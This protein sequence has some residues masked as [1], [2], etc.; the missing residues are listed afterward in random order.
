MSTVQLKP[1]CIN[2][3]SKNVIKHGVTIKGSPRF[4]C[5]DCEKT[6][7]ENNIKVFK[8]EVN[9]LTEEYLK[10]QTFRELVNLYKTAPI[11]IN[12]K[13]RAYLSQCPNWEEYIDKLTDE[14]QI[15]VI[16][17]T[18][19]SFA[20]SAAHTDDNS[21]YLALAV[22]LMSSLVIGFELGQKDNIEVWDNL[23]S[24]LSKRGYKASSFMSN[25]NLSIEK[26]VNCY[27]PN[28]NLRI[29]YFKAYREKEIECCLNLLPLKNKLVNDSLILYNQ[30]KNN[31]LSRILNSEY[32]TNLK[33][34]LTEFQHEYIKFLDKKIK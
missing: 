29:N 23:I 32:K 6:W 18:G 11:R 17:L 27:F 26:A 8:P 13:V 12:Q 34:Y 7:V 15:P 4:R 1:D 31:T 19:K 28:S 21:M 33:T 30:V 9:I 5:R 22:D 14:K 20:C 16:Y 24:R 10:G 25:G 2:C 3:G